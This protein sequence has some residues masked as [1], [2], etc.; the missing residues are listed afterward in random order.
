[1]TDSLIFIAHRKN[2][3]IR[4]ILQTRKYS[5]HCNHIIK[6]GQQNATIVVSLEKFDMISLFGRYF[7]EAI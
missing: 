6:D 3:G 1:M 5:A 2:P 4:D 7:R